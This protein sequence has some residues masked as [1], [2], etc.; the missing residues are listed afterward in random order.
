MGHMSE[1]TNYIVFVSLKVVGILANSVNPEEFY[2]GLHCL[3]KYLFVY[4][5]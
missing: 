2:L 3:P 5:V 4:P 1:F